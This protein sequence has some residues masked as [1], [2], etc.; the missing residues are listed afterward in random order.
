MIFWK[1][2]I[3]ALLLIKNKNPS[4]SEYMKL[5]IRNFCQFS[6]FKY[7]SKWKESGIDNIGK[8]FDNH[9]ELKSFHCIKNEFNC[10]NFLRYFQIVNNIPQDWKLKI[11]DSILVREETENES[12]LLLKLIKTKKDIKKIY[13]VLKNKILIPP[14]KKIEKWK[15][16]FT[17]LEDSDFSYFFQISKSCTKDT[18][19][20]YFQYK[21]LHRILTTN[22]F[23]FKINYNDSPNCSFCNQFQETL[24]H[25]FFECKI[26]N[27]LWIELFSWLS[28]RLEN[29][30]LSLYH[31]PQTILLG[32]K[33]ISPL[34]NHIFLI[35]KKYIYNCKIENK[36]PLFSVV[37]G[38]ILLCRKIEFFIEKSKGNLSKFDEKWSILTIESD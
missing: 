18:S 26:I 32:D 13:E 21:I 38:K 25:L 37:K 24:T 28:N 20:I 4:I 15:R 2:V 16:E 5:D 6:D 30:N 19:L 27:D 22:T 33:K 14:T 10:K 3:E 36:A 34:M 12:N 11:K 17:E 8:F 29:F 35:C 31:K 7:F 9:G 23:L 1:N